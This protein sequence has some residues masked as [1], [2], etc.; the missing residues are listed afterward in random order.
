MFLP[1]LRRCVPTPAEKSYAH[2]NADTFWNFYE[3]KGW[4]VGKERMKSWH[5]AVAYIFL[6]PRMLGRL[7][8]YS[9]LCI[10]KSI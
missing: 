4:T 6:L 3:S 5:G 1:R 9:Y 10:I 7:E 2:V 8:K